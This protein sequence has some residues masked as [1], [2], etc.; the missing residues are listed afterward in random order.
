MSLRSKGV[1]PWLWFQHQKHPK[2]KFSL[3]SVFF[4]LFFAA[5]AAPSFPSSTET[6]AEPQQR[7]HSTYVPKFM[8]SSNLPGPF[9]QV[10]TALRKWMMKFGMFTDFF[11][12]TNTIST[13][14]AE[15][16][17]NYFPVYSDAELI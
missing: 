1:E 17:V 11:G 16:L 4:G 2:V 12:R 14:G 3:S 6:K 15:Q 10:V 8:S 7:F 5:T 9:C 13:S